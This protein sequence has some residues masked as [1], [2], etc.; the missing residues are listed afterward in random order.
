MNKNK[1][2]SAYMAE[3]GARGGAVKS[4]RKATSSAENGKK[5]GRHKKSDMEIDVTKNG[6]PRKL[7]LVNDGGRQYGLY[8]VYPPDRGGQIAMA[9]TRYQPGKDEGFPDIRFCAKKAGFEV[10]E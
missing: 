4:E 1:I 2:I 8:V 5:G 7:R 10:V 6:K 3:I 9:R